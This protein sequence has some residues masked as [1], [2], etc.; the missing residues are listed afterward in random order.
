M[1]R[2]VPL[3]GYADLPAGCDRAY[4]VRSHLRAH[5]QPGLELLKQG[6]SCH[7]PARRVAL[8]AISKAT[9]SR[10]V[11]TQRQDR[12]DREAALVSS[13]PAWSCRF[14]R[15]GV[16][17]RGARVTPLF[18]CSQC[19]RTTKD[20]VTAIRR[21]TLCSGATEEDR[22]A[23]SD[24]AVRCAQVADIIRDVEQQDAE[25]RRQRLR[26]KCN[27]LAHARRVGSMQ[28]LANGPSL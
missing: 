10:R 9:Q 15:A 16:V 19:W 26:D 1:V 28:R 5:G 18:Q 13:L 21:A 23:A 20:R 14:R 2:S 11:A 8:A 3:C 22:A 7:D 12:L 24:I 6:R 25:R 17:P 27:V 4:T